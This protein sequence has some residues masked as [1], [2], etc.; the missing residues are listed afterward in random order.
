MIFFQNKYLNIPYTSLLVLIACAEMNCFFLFRFYLVL[1]ELIVWSRWR[2]FVCRKKCDSLAMPVW[3]WQMEIAVTLYWAKIRE[4]SCFWQDSS[5]WIRYSK[6]GFGLWAKPSLLASCFAS[7]EPLPTTF[8]WEETS[9][10]PA[11]LQLWAFP[12]SLQVGA[13]VWE[14]RR[15]E[16]SRVE[17]ECDHSI[18][19]HHN[20]YRTGLSPCVELL[21]FCCWFFYCYCLFGFLFVCF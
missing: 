7:W 4:C 18:R 6:A 8:S 5:F 21:L 16:Y 15:S 3:K 2:I 12:A 14:G 13:G 10:L 9:W 11:A 19:K 17:W 1:E 20:I